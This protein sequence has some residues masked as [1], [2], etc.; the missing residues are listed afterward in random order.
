MNKVKAATL[1][2]A[3][4]TL[5]P[6]TAA[7][8]A[9]LLRIL[10]NE[11]I[12]ET[13]MLPEFGSEAEALPLARRLQALSVSPEHVLYG[14]FLDGTLIGFINDVECHGDTIEMGYVIHPD[15]RGN[16]YATEAFAAVI[17]QLLS[18]GFREIRAGAFTGNLASIRVM[19]KCA[20]TPTGREETIPYRG[21]P[22]RCIGY[23][24]TPDTVTD[25][26][27]RMEVLFDDLLQ[28]TDQTPAFREKLAQLT[29]YYE[30]GRWLRHYEMD[31]AGL[32]PQNLKRGVL[33]QDG[34]FDLLASLATE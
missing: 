30:G 22:R 27:R 1:A 2:T 17:R 31:E 16:G 12:A 6:I 18:M 29:D 9:R 32:L 5:G 33:S 14:I 15:Y 24:L 10:T 34:V 3:R 20:M 28:C 19:E 23:H 8:E 26:I 13:Y 21:H 4:L 7:E 25:E 11:E